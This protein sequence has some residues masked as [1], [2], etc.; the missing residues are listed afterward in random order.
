MSKSITLKRYRKVYEK[1]V[2]VEKN[3]HLSA[4]RETGKYRDKENIKNKGE[5]DYREFLKSESKKEKY[6]KML[7]VERMKTIASVWKRDR[8]QL[9]RATRTIK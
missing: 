3:R 4:S 5:N 6:K 8:K 1:Y 2:K 7:P 9:K